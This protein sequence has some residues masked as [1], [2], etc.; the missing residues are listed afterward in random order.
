MKEILGG[1]KEGF[2]L[3]A[4]SLTLQH[5]IHLANMHL[6]K[7]NNRYSL[8]MKH[9]T[10]GR[11]TLNFVLIDEYQAGETRKI[12]TASGG[13][14]FLISLALA[15]G[16]SDLSSKHV[17]ISSLFID[18]GFGTL[19][20]QTLETVLSSIETLQAQGKTIGVI[21]HVQG[22]KERISTQ[23]QVI[24][25]QNGISGIQIVQP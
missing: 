8:E 19:D 23:I 16:L 20:A 2:S 7:L 25:K 10:K 18:E 12:S 6:H 9:D 24:K 17:Q 14:K 3:Y 22:L 4:Q 13:E 21:S 5:L 1:T 11:P 15:P